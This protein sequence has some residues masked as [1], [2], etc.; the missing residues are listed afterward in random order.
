MLRGESVARVSEVSRISTAI[1]VVNLELEAHHCFFVSRLG[2]LAHNWCEKAAQIH[3]DSELDRIM[4][5]F[6]DPVTGE[7]VREPAF[8]NN[9][10]LGYGHRSNYRERARAFG[11]PLEDGKVTGRIKRAVNEASAATTKPDYVG[12][13]TVAW[14]DLPA[15]TRVNAELKTVRDGRSIRSQLMRLTDGG[16]RN[17]GSLL[18]QAGF[19]VTQTP[20]E[21]VF[22][23]DV[24]HAEGYIRGGNVQQ[25]AREALA[26]VRSVINDS[27]LPYGD[28]GDAYPRI[29]FMVKDLS[30][31]LRI[32]EPV[33][34]PRLGE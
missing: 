6:R 23:L 14:G 1:R 7:I 30:G 5:P 11:I 29:A 8:R 12:D 13:L 22:I 27:T 2:L 24:S 4:N 33:R 31:A 32:T 16:S 19:R 10:Y 17:K 26:E 3:L 28:L 18:T 15:G 9:Q 21:H 20:G 34:M 25:Q